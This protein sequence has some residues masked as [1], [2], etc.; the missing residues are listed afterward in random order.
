MPS[1]VRGNL[2]RPCPRRMPE[3]SKTTG[4]PERALWAAILADAVEICIGHTP[5]SAEES[6]A[7]RRWVEQERSQFG[8]FSW[9][10]DLLGLDDG[11][12]RERILRRMDRVTSITRQR[13]L[14]GCRAQ[15]PL[16]AAPQRSPSV[17]VSGR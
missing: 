13:W 17:I 10:C 6:Q 3:T 4:G 11:A 5:A 2:P 7:A 8:G 9:C 1:T 12:I 16:M 15:R 14:P